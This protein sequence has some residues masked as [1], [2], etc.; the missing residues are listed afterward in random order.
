[1]RTRSTIWTGHGHIVCRS[2]SVMANKKQNRKQNNTKIIVL[3]RRCD[4]P[5]QQSHQ[6]SNLCKPK[7]ESRQWTIDL[8]WSRY[9]FVVP[10]LAT[11]T[12]IKYLAYWDMLLMNITYIL[13]SCWAAWWVDRN[14]ACIEMNFLFIRYYNS[15]PSCTQCT[16][17]AIYIDTQC[18][19]YW[20]LVPSIHR[21]LPMLC[22]HDV[23]CAM[24]IVDDPA[25]HCAGPRNVR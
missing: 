25:N 11:H 22:M 23:Q 19:Y 13:I 7:W 1:M 15:H 8:I 24:C 20:T 3:G 14:P 9:S 12:Q 21:V 6:T 16:D 10:L 2:A 5:T 18:N 4:H 17:A